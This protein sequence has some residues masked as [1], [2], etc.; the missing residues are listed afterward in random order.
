MGTAAREGK[1]PREGRGRLAAFREAVSGALGPHV[2]DAVLE[3][4]ADEVQA[5]ATSTPAPAPRAIPSEAAEPGENRAAREQSLQTLLRMA[6]GLSEE[7]L[8][9]LLD[10]ARR[11]VER[12]K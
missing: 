8:K 9:L 7:D 4:A 3:P 2:P 6:R 1:T 12:S 5:L 10:L 11:L